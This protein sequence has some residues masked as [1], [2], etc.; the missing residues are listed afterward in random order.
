MEIQTVL[1]APGIGDLRE[2]EGFFRVTPLDRVFALAKDF[3]VVETEHIPIME[4]V[5]RIL[6]EPIVAATDL[7]G[8]ARSTMDGYALSAASTFGASESN[9]AL[10]EITGEIRMGK[11]PEKRINPGEA[12]RIATGAMMPE[13]AD[14]V[15][16]VEY[17]EE[18]DPDSLE[19]YRSVAPGTNVIAKDEDF[20]QDTLALKPGTRLRPQE[21]GLLAALGHTGV[22]VFKKPRV[23]IIS[24]GDELCEIKE[25]PVAGRIRDINTYTLS[26]MARA[27]GA[28]TVSYGII[29]DEFEPLLDACKQCLSES[30]M[31]I[32]SG[33]SSVGTRDLTLSVIESLPDA[34]ILVHGIPVSPGKPTILARAGGKQLWGL[35]GHVT[36]AMVVF[37]RIVKFFLESLSGMDPSFTR[38]F[39]IPARLSRNIASAKGRI[40]FIRVRLYPGE[41]GVL[42]AEPVPGKSGLIRTMVA[43]D[44]LIEIGMNT[45]GLEKGEEVAVI[46]I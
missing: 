26:A 11:I 8:F 2:M 43:A 44:G 35:P 45:E 37:N 41:D 17:T 13:G 6:A 23:G 22:H 38:E 25:T 27:A 10:L 9:P 21:I 1:T 28:Q 12:M 24:T 3:G 19:I 32:I 7:P 14:A 30:D 46:P 36:S 33:G 40:D 5:F 29:P 15:I 39:S 4:A 18:I 16:M 20:K 31:I 42:T 34:E